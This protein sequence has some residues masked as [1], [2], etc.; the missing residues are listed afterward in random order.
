MKLA[1]DK[2]YLYLLAYYN[3]KPKPTF[4]ELSK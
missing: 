4:V 1:N 3:G 2:V